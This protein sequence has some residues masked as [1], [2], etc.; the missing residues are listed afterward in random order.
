MTWASEV[1]LRALGVQVVVD[2]SHP[3]ED[4]QAC[5]WCTS[6]TTAVPVMGW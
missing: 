6:S 5:R 2:D 3:S 1:A 4:P